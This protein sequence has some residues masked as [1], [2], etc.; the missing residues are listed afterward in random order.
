MANHPELHAVGQQP[1]R[2]DG[3]VEELV[4]TVQ[5]GTGCEGGQRLGEVGGILLPRAFRSFDVRGDRQGRNG[6]RL[7]QPQPVARDRPLDV[8]W[9]ESSRFGFPRERGHAPRELWP[10][11]LL[12]LRDD[13]RVLV[14]DEPFVSID[15][16]AHE[17]VSETPRGTHAHLVTVAGERIGRERD[18]GHLGLDHLLHQN[19]H[20]ANDMAVAFDAPVMCRLHAGRCGV[21]H[22][23][24][25]QHVEQ[26]VVLA[27]ERRVGQILRQAG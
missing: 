18:A 20:R 7:Q 10:N 6:P 16:A 24:G 23:L 8:L 11:G 21:Q 17:L 5:H 25:T 2:R 27:G 19:R 3:I 9:R 14:G 12:W 13:R 15:G 4:R 22:G 26:R 1:P